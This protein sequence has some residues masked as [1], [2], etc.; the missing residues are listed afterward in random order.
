[1]T[2][3]STNS[4]SQQ[5]N[6]KATLPSSLAAINRQMAGVRRLADE[7]QD[8]ERQNHDSI[9]LLTTTLDALDEG[10]VI[11]DSTGKILKINKT[12]ERVWDYK[13]DEL[14]GQDLDILVSGS[15]R[16]RNAPGLSQYLRTQDANMGGRPMEVEGLRKDGTAFPLEARFHEIQIPGQRLFTLLVRELTLH[17]RAEDM[18][19]PTEARQRALSEAAPLFQLQDSAAAVDARPGQLIGRKEGSYPAMELKQ[20]LNIIWRWLWLV[21]LCGTVGGL[22]AF[23]VSQMT[24]PTYQAST[25]LLV[26]QEASLG[27]ASQNYDA[28]QVNQILA[29]TYAS[30]LNKCPV[31]EAVVTDLRLAVDPELLANRVHAVPDASAPLLVLTV[32]DTDPQR[33]ADIANEIV[34]VFNAQNRDQQNQRYTATK[35]S[36]E[37][38]L[39]S[40]QVDIDRTQAQLDTRGCAPPPHPHPQLY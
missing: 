24:T 6:G 1:M 36:L 29:K 7:L 4:S 14:L 26:S 12:V 31:L 35:R 13:S 32:E 21:V 5:N 17:E 39:A 15:W 40:V 10:I 16:S 11:V 28:L 9:R 18:P 23:S 33:A 30:L 38:E 8:R 20:Y 27:S 2:P 25:T 3:L 34:N 22:T 19:Q 37:E